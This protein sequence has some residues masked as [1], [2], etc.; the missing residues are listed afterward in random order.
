MYEKRILPKCTLKLNK[1]LDMDFLGGNVISLRE[2]VVDIGIP[3]GMPSGCH[4]LN[5]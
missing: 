5:W 4:P 2:I 1:L 3:P